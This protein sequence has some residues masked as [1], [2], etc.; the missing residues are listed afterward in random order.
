MANPLRLL[1]A[2]RRSPY[3]CGGC[4]GLSRLQPRHNTVA[5]LITFAIVVVSAT[6]LLKFGF[7]TALVCFAGL[8]IIVAGGVM[9]LFMRLQPL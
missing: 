7:P 9:W 1:T 3:R 6:A 4:G 2:T 5:A 8:Y